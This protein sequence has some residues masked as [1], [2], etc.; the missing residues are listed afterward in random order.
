MALEL[1]HSREL[2]VRNSW[3]DKETRESARAAAEA[4]AMAEQ[5]A[6]ARRA[7]AEAEAA[8]QQEIQDRMYATALSAPGRHGLSLPTS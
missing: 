8:R 2:A 3:E 5:M 7:R 1:Q 4:Q 6:Q